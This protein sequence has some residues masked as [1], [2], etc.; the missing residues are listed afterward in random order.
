[1]RCGAV[2]RELSC[3]GMRCG[4]ACRQGLRTQHSMR[5]HFLLSAPSL[6][7]APRRVAWQLK[8]VLRHS[9]SAAP[10]TIIFLH[11]FSII[12]G[13]FFFMNNNVCLDVTIT[14]I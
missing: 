11:F 10:R 6:V 4:A 7:G 9:V 14:G 3:A 1:M 13:D 5:M 2:Q 12:A 8:S